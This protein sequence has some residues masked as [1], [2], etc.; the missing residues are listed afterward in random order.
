MWVVGSAITVIFAFL[1]PYITFKGEHVTL[2]HISPA[3]FIPPVALLVIPIVGN[4]LIGHFSGWAD[5]W[6]IFANYFGLG[7]GFFI[8]LALLAVSIVSVHHPPSTAE[9]P[10]SHHLDQ[11]R[12][13]RRYDHRPL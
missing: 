12:A 9:R 4:S 3:L 13:D 2:D 11:P 5:E 7:A 1:V 10:R 8:Y 6:I